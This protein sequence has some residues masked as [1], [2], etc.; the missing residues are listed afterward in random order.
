M[1]N[2][3][4][5]AFFWWIVVSSQ[6]H[7]FPQFCSYVPLLL[8]TSF[9][10]YRV[11]FEGSMP[12]YVENFVRDD[13]GWD[14]TTRQGIV[15]T[16]S[17]LCKQRGEELR[18]RLLSSLIS[19]TLRN[20]WLSAVEDNC[21][22]SA[23]NSDDSYV[24]TSVYTIAFSCL[25]SSYA[26]NDKTTVYTAIKMCRPIDGPF[27]LN[28][29]PNFA[30]LLHHSRWPM[31][32]KISKQWQSGISRRLIY[33]YILAS[34]ALFC[35]FV[36]FFWSQSHVLYLDLTFPIRSYFL[37]PRVIDLGSFL[38]LKYWLHIASAN[39]FA[40]R[41]FHAEIPCTLT[42]AKFCSIVN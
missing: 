38:A 31:V 26:L 7:R 25:S 30:E 21:Q 19:P 4:Q 5:D 42:L 15:H 1:V 3:N 17:N 36:Y 16:N 24:C 34:L 33:L 35:L 41:R 39:A 28:W 29:R 9:V 22:S 18:I 2:N 6:L 23:Q 12:W 14:L 13:D 10:T 32:G 8:R 11:T 40:Y 20:L 27:P 37:S